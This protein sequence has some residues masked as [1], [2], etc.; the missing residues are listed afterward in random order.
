MGFFWAET[1]LLLTNVCHGAAS[2]ERRYFY[3]THPDALQR[4]GDP[5]V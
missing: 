5:G 3:L 4:G 2:T 1:L